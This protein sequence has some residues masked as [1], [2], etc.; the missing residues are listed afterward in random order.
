MANEYKKQEIRDLYYIIYNNR[1]KDGMKPDEAKRVALDA[2]SLR[3]GITNDRVRHI[4]YDKD[5]DNPAYRTFVYMN[6][7][8]IVNSLGE[9]VAT[10]KNSLDILRQSLEAAPDKAGKDI[11]EKK[12]K[13]VET[14]IE[15]YNDLIGIITEVNAHYISRKK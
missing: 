1:L 3:F 15:K 14:K 6:N 10:Y 5:I 11:F 8:E 13:T 12:I 9:L 4:L 2:A 7:Q